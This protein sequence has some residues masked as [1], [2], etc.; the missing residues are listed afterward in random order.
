MLWGP[1][2]PELGLMLAYALLPELLLGLGCFSLQS[3]CPLNPS[4]RRP[5]LKWPSLPEG[6]TLKRCRRWPGL[7][8][9]VEPQVCKCLTGGLEA[10]LDSWDTSVPL[11]FSVS[12]GQNSFL[13]YLMERDGGQ[14]AVEILKFKIMPLFLGSEFRRWLGVEF[15]AFREIICSLAP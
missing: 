6:S 10:S 7:G 5:R 3:W 9:L 1:G 2:S 14:E 11:F 8:L 13:G 12:S 15:P 4:S